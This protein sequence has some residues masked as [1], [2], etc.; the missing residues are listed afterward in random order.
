[1]KPKLRTYRIITCRRLIINDN[2]PSNSRFEI[3]ETSQE[4]GKLVIQLL[5]G[6]SQRG[7]MTR[8]IAGKI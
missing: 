4:L 6:E 1:M 2:K 5:F 8:F 3:V 7:A